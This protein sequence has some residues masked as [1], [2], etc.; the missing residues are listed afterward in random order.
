MNR[1]VYWKVRK[2]CLNCIFNFKKLL[3]RIIHHMARNKEYKPFREV[4]IKRLFWGMLKSIIVTYIVFYI[5]GLIL[6]LYCVPIIDKEIFADVLIGGIGVAGVILGLYCAN[7]ASIY[8]SKYA[9]ASTD[10]SDAFQYDMLS[11]RCIEGIVN[12]IIFG[13]TVLVVIMSKSKISWLVV[14]VSIG[15][16]IIVVVSYSIA[17]NRAYQLSDVY[18]IAADTYRDLNRVVLKG[19]KSEVFSTDANF[20]NHLLNVAQDKINFLK[21]IQKYGAGV[22]KKDYSSMYEFMCHNLAGIEMY[23]LIKN[24]MSKSSLWFREDP[25]YKKWHFTSNTEISIA[26]QTGTFLRPEINRNYWWFE[27]EIF[28][29]NKE[30]FNILFEQHEYI[31]VCKYLSLFGKMSRTAI[32]HKQAN[33]Y[34]NQLDW[35]TKT[36]LRNVISEDAE[37]EDKKR[38]SVVLEVV[39]SLYSDL[40]LQIT[41]IYQEFDFESIVTNVIKAVD[42]GKNIE[43]NSCIRSRQDV[44]FYNNIITE[45]KVE[46]KRITPDWI[47]KQQIAKEEYVYLNLLIDIVREG[48]D[49]AFSLGKSFAEKGLDF[50]ACVILIRFYEY[51]TKLARFEDVIKYRKDELEKSRIDK[52]LIWDD[53]RLEKLRRTMSEWK[54]TIPPLLF[55]CASRFS[56]DNWENREEYPDF[57]GESYNHICEDAIEAIINDDITQFEIDF[58]NLSKLMLLYQEYIRTDFIQNKDIYRIEYA[59]YMFTSPIVEWAQIGGLAILWGEFHSNDEWTVC[60]KRGRDLILKENGKVTDLAEKLVEYVQHRDRFIIG[61]VGRDI[62][63]NNWQL[64][65]ENALRNSGIY[66]SEYNMFEHRLETKSKLLNAFCHNIVDLEFEADASEVF[67][68]MCVNPLLSSD[69]KYHTRSSW[70]DKISDEVI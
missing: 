48:L 11:R 25:K 41:K 43:K 46:N 51:E 10:I 60:A 29:I 33:C 4:I 39:S 64:N 7:K 44:D 32:D 22:D 58:N 57:L 13:F 66:E 16:S 31:L 55:N 2:I 21:S 27:N 62:I 8:S 20:Q 49:H 63:K 15:W 56:L 18:G 23:W 6:D 53:F 26:L 28:S 9:S 54:M 38:F 45:I 24:N 37:Y 67:W 68:V 65:V 59:Y 30:C 5:D 61:I 34:V 50:E 47:I 35:V 3:F 40:I 69:K 70:E 17:G 19:L 52:A 36:I 14:L 12:Y 42:T 1:K